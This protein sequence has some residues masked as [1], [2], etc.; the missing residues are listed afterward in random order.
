MALA[1]SIQVR[2]S[3]EAAESV[4]L[5]PVVVRDMPIDELLQHLAAAVSSDPERI[6]G[7]LK[8]GSL[9]S[10]ASRFRWQPFDP[11][12]DDLAQALASLPKSDPSRPF[13]PSRAVRVV[14]VAGVR[15]WELTR[16]AASARSPLWRLLARPCFWNRLLAILPPPGYVAYLH[17]DRADLYRAPVNDSLRPAI[18][19]AAALLPYPAMRAQLR[20]AAITAVEWLVER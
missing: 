5:T 9:V 13:D 4:S 20:A 14:L 16:A 15:R 11:P 19:D 7:L 2:I 3:S 17:K 18:H 6:R 12:L 8:R 10:G 1:P